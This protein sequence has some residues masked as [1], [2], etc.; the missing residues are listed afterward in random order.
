VVEQ[1]DGF[2]IVQ[3]H[4]DVRPIVEQSHPRRSGS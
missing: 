1:H 2:H 3:K 4:E